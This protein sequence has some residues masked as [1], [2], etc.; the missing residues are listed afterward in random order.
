MQELFKLH[1]IILHY[2]WVNITFVSYMTKETVYNYFKKLN[3]TYK[4]NFSIWTKR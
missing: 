3:Y 2:L 1:I 4:K